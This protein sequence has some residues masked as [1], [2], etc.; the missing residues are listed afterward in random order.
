MIEE[1]KH[2]SLNSSLLSHICFLQLDEEKTYYNAIFWYI[3]FME[4]DYKRIYYQQIA[5]TPPYFPQKR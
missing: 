5:Y 3:S 4:R 1:D 2:F